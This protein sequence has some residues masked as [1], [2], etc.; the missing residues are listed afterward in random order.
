M[1][2]HTLLL[3]ALCAFALPVVGGCAAFNVPSPSWPGSTPA[4]PGTTAWWRS[5]KNKAYFDPGKGFRVAGVDGYFDAEG[6]PINARVAKVVGDKEEARGL[7]ADA[8][9]KKHLG[10]IKES[11]GLGPNQTQAQADFNAAEEL[12]RREK[13][14]EAAKLYKKASA[15]WPDSQLE[16]DAMFML[17][18]SYFF[19]ARYPKATNAY[20]KLIRKYPNSPHLDKIITRQFAIARYWEQ[21]EHYN[22]NW[23]VTPNFFD[24]TR[25]L[26]DTIGRSIK[27]YENIRLND[28]TGPLADDAI[29]ATA[30]SHFLRGRWVDADE[31]YDLLRKE[32]PRS[33]HQFEAH[34]LGL[35]CK[36]RK[37]QGPSYDGAPLDE[38]KL[39][40]KQLKIQFSGKLDAEQRQRLADVDAQLT[41]ELATREFNMGQHFDNI[42]EYG[43][44]KYYYAQVMKNHPETPLANQAR[45][46]IQALAGEPDRPV[47]S[48]DPV[49]DLLPENA[50]RA[51]IAKVPLKT[52]GETR[53]AE[54]PKDR[55]LQ[56]E[57]EPKPGEAAGGETIRR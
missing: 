48:L 42:K 32:Y 17:A 10:G 3:L 20:E 27:N 38:A 12:F 1:P 52:D 11:V 19:G 5:H 50:E 44:A 14:S 35:Q 2:R 51:A 4:Q 39:L 34:I 43:S 23:P 26:F 7:L 25:Q 30:N 54:A 55:Q 33:D 49:L 21:Y 22:P 31:Q 24:K 8:N 40:V 36:L 37:Y 46:R 16:Q 47:S 45:D 53:L 15:G 6:R 13:Y 28:P 18:E 41:K 9:F 56:P 29:M 57:G